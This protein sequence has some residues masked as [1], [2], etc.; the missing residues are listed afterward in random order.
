MQSGYQEFYL[1]EREMGLFEIMSEDDKKNKY[2]EVF[3]QYE[4]DPFYWTPPNGES[5]AQLCLR[6]DRVLAHACI[7]NARTKEC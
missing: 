7:G 3:R 2:P 4:S 5:M 6:I 1:R